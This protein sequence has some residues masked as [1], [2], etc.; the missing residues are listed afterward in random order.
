MSLQ[1]F[2]EEPKEFFPKNCE[3]YEQGELDLGGK[4]LY[5]VVENV[6]KET[7][8]PISPCKY[9]LYTKCEARQ[10]PYRDR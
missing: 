5:T 8:D 4:F 7:E 10:E 1:R 3:W 9:C 2:L 6:R